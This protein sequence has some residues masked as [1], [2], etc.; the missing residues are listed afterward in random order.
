MK[1][2]ESG[3]RTLSGPGRTTLRMLRFKSEWK[4]TKGKRQRFRT[5]PARFGRPAA[6]IFRND[7]RVTVWLPGSDKYRVKNSAKLLATKRT[8]SPFSI[9][10]DDSCSFSYWKHKKNASIATSAKPISFRSGAVLHL[11]CSLFHS[12][13]RS[14]DHNPQQLSYKS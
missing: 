5:A 7:W 2:R 9:Q 13:T 12:T 10:T 11:T 8:A 1:W 6:A 14:R 3:L 4:N